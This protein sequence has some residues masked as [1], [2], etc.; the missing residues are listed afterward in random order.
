MFDRTFRTCVDGKYVSKDVK[1]GKYVVNTNLRAMHNYNPFETICG[2]TTPVSCYETLAVLQEFQLLGCGDNT[3]SYVDLDSTEG[4]SLAIQGRYPGAYGYGLYNTPSRV[5]WD[6]DRNGL[7]MDNFNLDSS[8]PRTLLA[9][10]LYYNSQGV[11]IS[12]IDLPTDGYDA[13]LR[14]GTNALAKDGSCLVRFDYQDVNV[15][16]LECLQSMF[17]RLQLYKP[18]VTSASSSECYLVCLY[19]KESTYYER[20]STHPDPILGSQVAILEAQRLIAEYSIA[21][22]VDNRDVASVNKARIQYLGTISL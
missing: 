9:R 1:G 15:S 11:H 12:F 17:E 13:Y 3:F 6:F 16:L 4:F 21:H 18:A 7:D 22:H 5:K 10:S 8:T 14:A 19:K 20:E 2:N